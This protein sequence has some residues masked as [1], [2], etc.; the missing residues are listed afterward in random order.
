MRVF[1]P[2]L[3]SDSESVTS[4]HHVIQSS[5]LRASMAYERL[6]ATEQLDGGRRPAYATFLKV[7]GD[8]REHERCER[9]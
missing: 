5:C 4:P 2:L 7:L 6:S 8:S 9:M 3:V 1:F